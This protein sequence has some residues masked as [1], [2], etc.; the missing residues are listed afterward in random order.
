MLNHKL[1]TYLILDEVKSVHHELGGLLLVHANCEH[2][3]HAA[4]EAIIE[5]E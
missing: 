2:S 1:L 4:C 3:Y 5:T